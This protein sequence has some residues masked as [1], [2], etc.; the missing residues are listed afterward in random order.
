MKLKNKTGSSKVFHISEEESD[1]SHVYLATRSRENRLYSDDIVRQL[2]NIP[3]DHP[4]FNEWRLRVQPMK[5]VLQELSSG[6]CKH[7]LDLG[8]GN[9]WFSSQMASNKQLDI[10]GADIN[11]VELE[12]AARLFSAQN[13]R[14]VYWNIFEKDKA[15]RKFDV[16]TLDSCLQYF[17]SPKKLITRLLEILQPTGSIFI[18]DTPI[19]RGTEVDEAERRSS[20]YFARLGKSDMN[21]FYHHHTWDDLA[22]FYYFLGY[23]PSTV[24]SKVKRKFLANDSPFPWII[25]PRSGEKA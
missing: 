19:Y 14:F 21:D 25:I 9:G 7:I 2:P 17:E 3:N 4:H 11:L 18:W 23:N 13:C 5:R 22:G 6:S 10:T 8:C 20:D 12:Q 1:F 16:I 24:F 15:G